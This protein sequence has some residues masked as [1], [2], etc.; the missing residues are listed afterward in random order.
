VILSKDLAL[1]SYITTICTKVNLTLRFTK[2]N[3]IGTPQELKRVAYIIFVRS[4]I[5]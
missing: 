1:S 4:G 5:A 2:G 3:L